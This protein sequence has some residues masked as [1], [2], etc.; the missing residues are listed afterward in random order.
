MSRDGTDVAEVAEEY[1]DSAP[2]DAFYYHVWGGEDIHVG[3]Y[4]TPDED[5]ATASRRTVERMAGLLSRLG[6]DTRVID[7]GAGY[8]GSA[9]QLARRYGCQ[10]ECLNLSEVQNEHNRRLTRE[11]GL[12]DRIT[13][14]HG[15]FEA[16]PAKD[17][18]F[19]VVWSQDAFLHGGDRRRVLEEAARV[20]V[21]GGELVF[22]DPM[23]ADDCP[24]D[25]LK[26][27]YERIHLDSLGSFAFYREALGE[28]GF[29]EVTCLDLTDQLR[30]HY[31]RVRRE[32]GDRYDE[33]C[34]VSTREYVD[35]MLKGLESWVQAADSG[36]LAWG[37]LH[38]RKKPS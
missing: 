1:Y 26:P 2:A 18:A 22:T 17:A 16:V 28:L 35:R 34:E 21:P 25:V 27:V 29:E 32:L 3:L 37:I 38:F 4:E 19:G 24:P 8:G 10:V 30:N 31:A 11:Q 23:Q 7:L 14:T 36:H 20:L 6:P 5:I 15:S 13:V 9:R 33:M 12:D